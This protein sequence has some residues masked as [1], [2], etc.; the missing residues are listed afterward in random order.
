MITNFSPEKSGKM[1]YKDPKKRYEASLKSIAKKPEHYRAKGVEAD[2]RRSKRGYFLK[3][4]YNITKEDYER[5]LESQGS[6]CKICGKPPRNTSQQTA[7]LHVDH[8]HTTG[9]V[10]G[11]LCGKC[12]TGLGFIEQEEL[13]K[14][15]KA[16]L[17]DYS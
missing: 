11:L 15:A 4:R 9:K 3:R 7:V 2:R 13:L 5:M 17:E 14:A 1:P 12:N 8:N 16:Y 6:V 10:R